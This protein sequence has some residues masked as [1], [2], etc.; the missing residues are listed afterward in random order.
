M[1]LF[2]VAKRSS[3]A[4]MGA[5]SVRCDAANSSNALLSERRSVSMSSDTALSLRSQ[6]ATSP[7]NDLASLCR[8]RLYLRVHR[9]HSVRPST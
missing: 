9:K 5:V 1:S 6:S 8:C 2:R 3:S 4:A 7:V